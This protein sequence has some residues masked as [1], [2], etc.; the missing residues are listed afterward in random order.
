VAKGGYVLQDSEGKADVIFVATGSEVSLAV[1]AA[2]KLKASGKRV[3]VVSMPS[4]TLFDKQPVAYRRSVLTPGV[5]VISIECLGVFG[6][7]RYSHAQIGMT[8]FGASAPLKD[9]M[10][11][12]GFTVDKVV[13]KTNA[14]LS[15]YDAQS[16]EAGVPFPGP[17][18]THFNAAL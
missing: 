6:W 1:D 3:R 16:R 2:A 4:T 9:V 17:L 10:N 15:Q 14:V 7:E 13:A 12:F 8:T 11:K 18:P 5:P